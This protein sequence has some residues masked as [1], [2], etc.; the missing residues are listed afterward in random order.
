MVHNRRYHNT[1][2]DFTIVVSHKLGIELLGIGCVD[3][4]IPRIIKRIWV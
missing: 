2:G 1:L 4:S 3:I